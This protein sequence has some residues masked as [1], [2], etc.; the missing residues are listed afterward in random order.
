MGSIVSAMLANPSLEEGQAK[1]RLVR[2]REGSRRVTE[3]VN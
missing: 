3:V 1:G 2:A